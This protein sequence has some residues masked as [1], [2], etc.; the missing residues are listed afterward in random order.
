MIT[1]PERIESNRY[2]RWVASHACFA[3]GIEGY[4]QCC[5]PNG[6]G[7]ATKA[8]DYL[9]FP[10]CCDRPGVV[11]RHSV[12]DRFLNGMTLEER[13]AREENYSGMMQGLARSAGWL[14]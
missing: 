3:C 6:A 11:G 4:S 12:H 5:H 8:S 10:L 2:R 14:L 7:G 13:Q 1:K 9:T